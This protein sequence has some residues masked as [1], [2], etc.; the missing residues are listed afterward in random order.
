[1]KSETYSD[2]H[3]TSTAEKIVALLSDGLTS[4]PS[5]YELVQLTESSLRL[6]CSASQSGLNRSGNLSGPTLLGFADFAAGLLALALSSFEE[7]IVTSAVQI[8]F[9]ASAATRSV[10]LDVQALRQGTRQIVCKVRIGSGLRCVA[11]GVVTF[12]RRGPRAG[13]P[14]LS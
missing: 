13:G 8:N 1:M 11:Y 6:R 10:D 5:T 7:G 14:P 12:I 2:V 3:E 4:P 9:L